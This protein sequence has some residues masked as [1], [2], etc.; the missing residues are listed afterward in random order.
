ML[1]TQEIGYFHLPVGYPKT[2]GNTPVTKQGVQEWIR[3]SNPS[4]FQKTSYGTY[5]GIIGILAG[6]VASIAGLFKDSK[7]LKWIGGIL[8]GVGVLTSAIGK[9]FGIEVD[10]LNKVRSKVLF[11]PNGKVETTPDEEGINHEKV[12]IQTNDGE[13]LRG[14]LFPAPVPTKKTVIFLNGRGHNASMCLKEKEFEKL[15]N[16]VPVNILIVDYRGFGESKSAGSP[17]PQG[18]VNDAVS[19][20]DYLISEKHLTPDDISVFGVSLGGA[21]AIELANK[22]E[23]DTLIV[24]SSFTTVEDVADDKLSEVIPAVLRGL[25]KGIT[26]SEFN[27]RESIKNVKAKKVIISH[28]TDDEVIPVKHGEELFSLVS[29]PEKYF[30][31]IEGVHHKDFAKGYDNECYEIFRRCLGVSAVCEDTKKQEVVAT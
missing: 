20:Y 13:T 4:F 1:R 15:Q 22:R 17:T 2:E 24:Q 27:S 29:V 8:A 21:V 11:S 16:E 25:V 18:V 14:F 5:L 10:V 12:E 26:Q 3:E 7:L 19:M 23:V 30:L 9:L 31:P 6:A 28:S